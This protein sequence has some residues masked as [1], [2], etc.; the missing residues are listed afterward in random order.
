[1]HLF[2]ELQ[3][4]VG[5]FFFEWDNQLYCS[6]TGELPVCNTS[7]LNE[8]LGQVVVISKIIYD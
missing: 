3:K 1:M 4:L 6:E 8:E 2:L 5:T 7:D